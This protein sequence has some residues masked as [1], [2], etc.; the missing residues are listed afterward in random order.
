[1]SR[2]ATKRQSQQKVSRKPAAKQE[3]PA[4]REPAKKPRKQEQE[5]EPQE[6]QSNGTELRHEFHD[7]IEN[8]KGLT[9][10]QVNQQFGDFG[11]G[12]LAKMLLRG[13][14]KVT[15]APAAKKTDSP[16][17]RVAR[18][19]YAKKVLSACGKARIEVVNKFRRRKA[20]A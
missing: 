10:A 12:R 18:L 19:A 4:K 7:A 20:S 2:T 17:D 8:G 13:D 3:K 16:N 5:P 9:V 15:A 1:M 14:Y 6:E 11:L